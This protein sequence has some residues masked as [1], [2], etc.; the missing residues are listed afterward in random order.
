M[1]RNRHSSEQTFDIRL[2]D[3]EALDS[4]DG[5]KTALRSIESVC[6]QAD[7]AIS[8]MV[9]ALSDRSY[10]F[11]YVFSRTLCTLV[12][13]CGS[14]GLIVFILVLDKKAYERLSRWIVS[15]FPTS[16][17][18]NFTDTLSMK[19]LQKLSSS[20][21]FAEYPSAADVPSDLRVFRKKV[22][23]SFKIL[24]ELEENT[25]STL[26]SGNIPLVNRNKGKPASKNHCIDPLLFDSMG[27]AVPTT[28]AGVRDALIEVLSQLR[29]ILEVCGFIYHTQLLTRT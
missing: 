17:T 4:T 28:D 18:P 25:N 3:A 14:P 9:M 21:L 19:L 5:F 13:V 8:E 29:T 20:L 11:E 27:I 6:F 23:L 24:K 1:P 26:T 22:E 10:V 12:V 7:P 15:G 16:T 2:L